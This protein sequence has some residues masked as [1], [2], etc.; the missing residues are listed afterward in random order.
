MGCDTPSIASADGIR[1]YLDESNRVN[2]TLGRQ[3]DIIQKII[4]V[5]FETSSNGGTIF[6]CGNGGST[7]D[8]MHLTEELVARFKRE[9]PGIKAQH[10]CDPSTI[11]CWTNDYDFEGV[12]ERQVRTFMTPRDVLVAFST[13]GKSPNIIR[14]L[15]AA[16]EIGA[17]TILLGGKTGG[18]AKQVADT[19]LIVDSSLTS[20]AQEAH[21]V[22]I[23]VLCDHL[24]Q[25]LFPSAP[26]PK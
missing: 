26:N 9:R 7:C 4:A 6:S 13:S 20:H 11:T 17:K 25:A 21:S 22:L 16:K 23:H 15:K 12:F 1:A 14:A 18:E 8:S 2:A 3:V 19:S 24:E 5:L 10:F